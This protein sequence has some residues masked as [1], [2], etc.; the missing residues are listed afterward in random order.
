MAPDHGKERLRVNL[1]EVADVR[2]AHDIEVATDY[3]NC[4]AGESRTSIGDAQDFGSS[5]H[6]GSTS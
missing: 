1:L 6:S 3:G 5:V 4:L 2:G